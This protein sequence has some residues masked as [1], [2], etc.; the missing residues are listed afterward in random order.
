ML[1]NKKQI[2]DYKTI[3]I[4]REDPYIWC[5]FLLDFRQV[6]PSMAYMRNIFL[7]QYPRVLAKIEHGG[8]FYLKKDTLTDLHTRVHVLNTPIKFKNKTLN[9]KNKLEEKEH[10]MK[11]EQVI[12]MLQ[13]ELPL[14]SS[15]TFKPM[16]YGL[17]KY[18][19]NTWT[20]LKSNITDFHMNMDIVSPIINFIKDV[21]CNADDVV[22]K[23]F[24]SWLRH[25]MVK[26]YRK[27]E[28]AVFLHSNAKGT[29]KGSLSYWLKNHVFGTHI[30][31]VIS[32]LSKL[33]QKH[34]TCIKQKILT[35][36]EEI[37]AIQGEFHSQF[38]AMKHL[39]TDPQVT[40]EPKGVDPYEIPN[41][42][43][44]LMM[45]NN[46]MALKIEKGDRRYACFEVSDCKRGDENYWN[47]IH[48]NVLTEE[49][50]KHF[51]QYIVNIPESECVSLRKIPKTKLRQQMIENSISAHDRFFS[52]IKDGLYNI[53]DG[54]FIDE[55]KTK[56]VIVTDAITSDALYK[57]YSSYCSSRGEKSLRHRL[58]FTA[59]SKHLEKHRSTINCKTIRYYTIK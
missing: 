21:I 55:F 26:P 58:F 23:Y 46:Q 11:L 14:Y 2:M 33:T 10:E 18:E 7:E 8:G 40:I 28:V 24:I 35:I 43:N 27:T 37:P 57:M 3:R 31:N 12:V 36:V 39:I 53:P 4:N 52:D 32:G 47:D 25:I 17:D 19:F 5:D 9:T 29:G 51:Y 20:S 45:S 48:D 6:F 13:D 16:D 54:A 38:D 42:V 22:Y 59:S 50:A 56:D 49:S 44:F 1:T 15:I 34:N 30:S 41:M